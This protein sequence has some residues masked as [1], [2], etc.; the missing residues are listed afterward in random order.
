MTSFMTSQSLFLTKDR[1]QQSSRLTRVII[2]DTNPARAAIEGKRLR[3]KN[4]LLLCHQTPRFNKTRSV[5][6]GLRLGTEVACS[7]A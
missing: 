7:M 5:L 6:G 1:I 2:I 3:K 4:K